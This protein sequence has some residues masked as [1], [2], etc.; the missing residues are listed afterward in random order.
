MYYN[1]ILVIDQFMPEVFFDPSD[2]LQGIIYREN[3]QQIK[4]NHFAIHYQKPIVKY[5][6]EL[7]QGEHVLIDL[8]QKTVEVNPSKTKYRYIEKEILGTKREVI[9]YESLCR[10]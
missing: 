4:F 1:F 2:R 6:G 7:K 3:N 8:E 10:F 9:L 5:Q